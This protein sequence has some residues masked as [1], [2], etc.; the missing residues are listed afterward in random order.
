MK[1][2]KTGSRVGERKVAVGFGHQLI[3]TFGRTA[4]FRI[5]MELV[6]L[7]FQKIGT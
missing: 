7:S 1:Y 5:Y 3:E 4:S 2:S 6:R